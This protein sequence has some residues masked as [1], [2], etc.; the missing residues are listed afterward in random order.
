M[1]PYILLEGF[2]GRTSLA[3]HHIKFIV[4]D[5]IIVLRSI[6]LIVDCPYYVKL[7]SI[8]LQRRYYKEQKCVI[9]AKL[10]SNSKR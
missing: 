5:D 6:V 10:E 1:V 9:Y 7:K 8:K 4:L 3:F 2:S